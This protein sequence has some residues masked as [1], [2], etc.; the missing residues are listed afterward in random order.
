MIEEVSEGLYLV[1]GA[2]R[3]RF[4]YSHSI[5]AVGD[6]IALFDTGCGAEAIREVTGRFPVDLVINSHTHPDHFSGNHHFR[7]HELWVPEMFADILP[8]LEAMS[9]RLAGEGDAARDWLH[10]VREILGHRPTPCTDRFRE[11]DV[12]DL[13]RL[14]LTA[15][16]T[17]GHTA[18]HFCFLEEGKGI[19]LSF[20]IDL[21]PFGP[22][23]GHVECDLG[24]FRSSLRR[25]RDLEPRMIVSS[26]RHPV[27]SG[28]REELDAFE[29]HFDARTMRIAGMLE[30]GSAMPEELSRV[31]P[32]YG[33]PQSDFPL[34]RYFE[35]RMIEKH[36]ELLVEE[37]GAVIMED[38]SYRLI[39]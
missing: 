20:D 15:L 9:L 14:R 13:G 16:H 29:A 2:N 26:H 33:V 22:W 38:G 6:A 8:D 34:F 27:T 24:D 23:Y 1:M 28:I 37:G 17:P 7:E 31:S 39:S 12:I 21:T 30:E 4:P 25:I 10:L 19:L 36:L 11:G 32:I 3:G 18:D 35:S 5:L